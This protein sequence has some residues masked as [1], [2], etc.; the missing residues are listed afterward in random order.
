M[1][2]NVSQSPGE[3]ALLQTYV[4]PRSVQIHQSSILGHG[5]TGVPRFTQGVGGADGDT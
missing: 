2:D 3:R 5:R 4:G 1:T